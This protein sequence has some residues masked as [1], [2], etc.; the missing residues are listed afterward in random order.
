[1]ASRAEEKK[2]LREEREARER[3]ER[4]A[5]AKRR[6]LMRIGIAGAVIVIAAVV[7]VVALSGGGGKKSSASNPKQDGLDVSPGPWGTNVDGLDKRVAKLGLPDPSDT[8]FHIHAQL[9]VYTDGKKQTVPQ[10]VG[11]N[12]DT[13]FLASLHTHDNTGVIHMEAVQPYKFTLG[14]FFTVW[15][16]AFTPTQIGAYHVNKAQNLVLQTWVNGKQIANAVNYVMKPHD[17]IVVGFGEPGSFP[18]TS[19]F[20]FPVG[21]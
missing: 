6:R 4:E 14:Q 21:E 5:H 13:Q 12:A 9:S 1:V 3:K 16:V 15:G 17:K 7:A 10:N 11:I 19:N 18:K 2:R 8:V 20:K